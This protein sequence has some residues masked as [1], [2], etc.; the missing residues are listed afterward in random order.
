[1]NVK[2][3]TWADKVAFVGMIVEIIHSKKS[4][5]GKKDGVIDPYHVR[6]RIPGG[7]CSYGD[8]TSME[9]A[10]ES[11]AIGMNMDW[12]SIEGKMIEREWKRMSHV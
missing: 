5:E 10:I 8:G 6:V 11:A 9:K 2:T 1:M 3:I 12:Y 4:W 7:L